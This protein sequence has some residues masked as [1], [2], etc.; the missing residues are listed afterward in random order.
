[1]SLATILTPER[2]QGCITGSSKK[3]VLEKVADFISADIP[4]LDAGVL[5]KQLIGREKLGS[6]GIGEGV[7]IPHCRIEKCPGI[8][9]ALIRLHEAVDFDAIDEQPVDLLFVLLVP[10][11][12]CEEHL[13]TLGEL[14]QFF[15]RAEVRQA[16]REA[17]DSAAMYDIAVNFSAANSAVAG[18]SG[19]T[20]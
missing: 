4:A 12:A 8:T 3:R 2:T 6:T 15:S 20:G 11:Q 14:A 18:T 5:F 13:Q 9:G 1:M 17:P 19:D 7:A 10:Q 16:L